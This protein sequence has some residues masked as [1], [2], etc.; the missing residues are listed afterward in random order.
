MNIIKRIRVKLLNS[1]S[2]MYINSFYQTL[3]EPTTDNIGIDTSFI[4]YYYDIVFLYC[5]EFKISYFVT[6]ILHRF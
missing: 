4:Y 3:H 1:L 5:L 2:T 6:I